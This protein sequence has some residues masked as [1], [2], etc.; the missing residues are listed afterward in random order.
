[1][2]SDA[3]TLQKVIITQQRHHVASYKF[4]KAEIVFALFSHFSKRVIVIKMALKSLKI[5][6]MCS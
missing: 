1:M 2:I 4:N 3:V 6:Y 5:T